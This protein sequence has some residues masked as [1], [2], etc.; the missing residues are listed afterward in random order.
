MQTKLKTLIGTVVA[1]SVLSITLPLSVGWG[2]TK[3][4]LY[5]SVLNQYP[6][7]TENEIFEYLNYVQSH[8]R[9]VRL[10]DNDDNHLNFYPRGAAQETV[11]DLGPSDLSKNLYQPED[12]VIMLTNAI[13]QTIRDE[14]LQQGNAKV[15]VEGV[16]IFEPVAT[17]GTN[18]KG[19]QHV[20]VH[21]DE[22]MP[23]SDL[24]QHF[25]EQLK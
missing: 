1:A 14:A 11:I 18:K 2:M 24:M 6:D 21:F 5:L 4:A 16:G 15:F 12:K 23:A 9:G 7:I 3:P 8:G 19:V 20:G 25:T 13:H 22:L 10:V 17:V